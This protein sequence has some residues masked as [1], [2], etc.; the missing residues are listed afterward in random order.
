MGGRMRESH[1]HRIESLDAAQP[2]IAA[3]IQR[4]MVAAYRV[5][6]GLLGV[7]DFVPL[8]RGIE[9]IRA[10]E[11]RFLGAFLGGELAGVAELE[12]G[13]GQKAHVASLVVLP[14]HFRQ[15]IASSLLRHVI[16]LHG[17]TG[18]TVSTGQANR[19]ALRL[20]ARLG[21]EE[22]RLWRTPDGIPMVTLA[23]HGG[24]QIVG[25]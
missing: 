3:A 25:E 6:A 18:I 21:F 2:E 23:Y 13:D 12:P 11:S 22:Q 9:A 24:R 5:E 1:P 4:V 19:P 17:R 7:A 16:G 15:G 14:R 10:A 8:Q 20:Y